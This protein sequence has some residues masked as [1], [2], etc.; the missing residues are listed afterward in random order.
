MAGAP[1]LERLASSR[2]WSGGA[3][4]RLAS[5]CA[6]VLASRTRLVAADPAA[7]H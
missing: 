2:H 1:L 5:V 7:R 4:L 6:S 3:K